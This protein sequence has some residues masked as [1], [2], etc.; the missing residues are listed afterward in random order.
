MVLETPS[1]R[2]GLDYSE[3]PGKG[4]V[5]SKKANDKDDDS[6][7]KLANSI[8]DIE[9]EEEIIFQED[10]ELTLF[11]KTKLNLKLVT[12]TLRGFAAPQ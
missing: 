8:I 6:I 9:K 1:R 7:T 5:E 3:I 12:A 2:I 4:T 10:N 11:L